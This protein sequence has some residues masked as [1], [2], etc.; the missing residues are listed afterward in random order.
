MDFVW[1]LNNDAIVDKDCLHN[2]VK[3]SNKKENVGLASPLIFNNK[4]E[5][6]LLYCATSIDLQKGTKKQAQNLDEF[7][8]WQNTKPET[9]CLWG[10]ALLLKNELIEDIGFLDERFFAY[11]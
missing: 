2:L 5:Q 7:H 8:Q 1:L 4:I 3:A 11:S 9:I 6:K 10:T